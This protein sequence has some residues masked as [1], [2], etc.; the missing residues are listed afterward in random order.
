[1]IFG[2]HGETSKFY[3]AK[4]EDIAQLKNE[5]EEYYYPYF[6]FSSTRLNF[7]LFTTNKNQLYIIKRIR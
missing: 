7:K 2:K 3:E 1:M 6:Y 5:L 4:G